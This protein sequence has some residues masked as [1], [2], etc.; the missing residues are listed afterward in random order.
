MK[1]LVFIAAFLPL[2][3]TAQTCS[4]G[5][6]AQYKDAAAL[7]ISAVAQDYCVAY[8]SAVL[9]APT[10]DKS[11]LTNMSKISDAAT[12]AHKGAAFAR[13]IDSNGLC[14]QAKAKSPVVS[15]CVDAGGLYYFTNLTCNPGDRLIS[16]MR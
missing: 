6:Y 9:I 12:A 1:R 4:P 10:R 3:A 2:L 8:Y 11:C 16:K 13:L 14:A 7:N 5:E 15:K